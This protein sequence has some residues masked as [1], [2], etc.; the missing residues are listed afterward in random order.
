MQMAEN[1]HDKYRRTLTAMP[2]YVTTNTIDGNKKIALFS[3]DGSSI[4]WGTERTVRCEDL[5][6]TDLQPASAA[7]TSP[8]SACRVYG[9][10]RY[11]ASRAFTSIHT[12][13]HSACTRYGT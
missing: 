1:T 10:L 6:A 3:G 4:A 12:Q 11:T 8:F 9:A 5:K 7:L 2:K 13:R